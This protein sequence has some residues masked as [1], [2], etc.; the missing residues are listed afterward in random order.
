MEKVFNE[1]G[2]DFKKMQKQEKK[3]FLFN[4]ITERM[5]IV[6][7]GVSRH[8]GENV[9]YNKTDYYKSLTEDE[10]KSF[11]KYLKNKGKK[12]LLFSLAFLAPMLC[13]IFLNTRFTGKVIGE[14][15]GESFSLS[16]SYFLIFFMVIIICILVFASA[17][18]KLRNKRFDRHLKIIDEVLANRIRIK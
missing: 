8:F 17:I 18:K 9:P 11:E 6:E 10:K 5:I 13:L 14:N 12:R 4:D 7:Q 16:F 1:T 2:E 15:I 3:R